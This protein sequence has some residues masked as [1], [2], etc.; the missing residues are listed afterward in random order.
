MTPKT[1]LVQSLSEELILELTEELVAI[2]SRNPPGEERA[3]AEFISKRF[4]E[5]GIE[6]EMVLE[7]DPER[8]QVVAWCRGVGNQPTVILNGHIDTVGEG[9]AAEWRYPPFKA[10]RVDDRLYGRGTCDMKGSLA[11][12]MAILKTL[13]DAGTK[14]P[15]TLMF[16]AV[17]G[18]EMDEEGTR[19][20]LKKGYTGDYALVLEPTDL[21]IGAGTRGVTWHRITLS[22]PSVHCGLAEPNA[23][24]LMY[25]FARLLTAFESYHREISSRPHHLI[26][27]PAFRVTDVRAGGVHND[28]V[29]HCELVVDR[30]M[31]PNETIEQVTEEIRQII[32][33]V[34]RDAP[35]YA[36]ELEFMRWNEPTEILLDSPLVETLARNLREIEGKQPEI[37]GPPYGCDMRNFVYDAGIP[38][39]I[40]GSGD[41]R[42]CHKPDEFVPVDDLLTCARIILGTVIDLLAGR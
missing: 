40:F 22:G 21:R 24:D 14:F 35:E 39:V 20:L 7:P 15:G 26:P 29:G 13:N 9:N 38:T 11:I 28:I 42:V 1:T 37:W 12:A 3:C 6:N 30:R 36:Y 2:P 41:F 27:S 18:E 17:M 10:T 34:L 19:T 16:Q 32:E 23:P 33:R 25:Q 5:W 4:Q 8:P 31:I